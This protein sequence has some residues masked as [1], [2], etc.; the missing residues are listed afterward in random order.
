MALTSVLFGNEYYSRRHFFKGS[1]GYVLSNR[2]TSPVLLK[3][4]LLYNL[5]PA[6]VNKNYLAPLEI[7]DLC[8]HGEK[9]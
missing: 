2:P 7:L 8:W 5:Q 4:W 3:Y 9:E 1:K 6:K